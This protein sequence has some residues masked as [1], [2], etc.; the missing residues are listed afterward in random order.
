MYF[1][2]TSTHGQHK[3]NKSQI[4]INQV[5]ERVRVAAERYQEACCGKMVLAG[6]GDWEKVLWVLEDG[7]IRGYQDVEKLQTHIGHPGMLEDGQVAAVEV[8]T[9]VDSNDNDDDD[10]K[11]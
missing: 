11:T 4:I 10:D 2:N 5:H 6:A 1:K 8:A 7:N 3:G 9:T